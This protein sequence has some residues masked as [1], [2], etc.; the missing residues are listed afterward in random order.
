M[1]RQ[2]AQRER[3]REHHDHWGDRAGGGANRVGGEEEEA[4]DSPVLGL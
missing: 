4:E 2:P 3:E 1:K